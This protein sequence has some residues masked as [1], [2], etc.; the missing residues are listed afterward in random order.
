MTVS[1]IVGAARMA[2]ETTSSPAQILAALNRRLFG[3]LQGGFATCIVLRLNSKGGCTL[4]SAGHPAPFL[5]S[6]EPSIPGALPLG[7][8]AD[9]TYDEVTLCLN[10]GDYVALYTDGLLEARSTAGELY[11]FDRLKALF[12]E[13]P[14]AEQAAKAAVAFG[15]DD[16]ITVLTPTRLATREESTAPHSSPELA[17]A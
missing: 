1:L 9:A 14:T 7:L 17:P 15:Q 8:F 13:R 12:A 5:N 4:S 11:S 10:S 6:Q 16:D 3:R 2:A